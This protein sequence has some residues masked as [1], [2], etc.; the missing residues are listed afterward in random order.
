MQGAG[1][2]G[3]CLGYELFRAARHAPNSVNPSRRASRYT[4]KNF[5]QRLM[6]P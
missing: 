6:N 2:L 1:L 3:G 4:E 5:F